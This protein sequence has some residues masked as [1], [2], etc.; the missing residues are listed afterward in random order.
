MRYKQSKS[1]FKEREP[2]QLSVSFV[3]NYPVSNSHAAHAVW[4]LVASSPECSPTPIKHILYRLKLTCIIW[5]QNIRRE[6]SMMDGYK[7]PIVFPL[8]TF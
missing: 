8:K 4:R 5:L 2:P 6:S 7:Y 3:A 1:Y